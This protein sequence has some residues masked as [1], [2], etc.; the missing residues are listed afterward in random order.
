MLRS[1]SRAAPVI[2]RNALAEANAFFDYHLRE[3]ALLLR[4]QAYGFAR[5]PGCRQRVPGYDFVVQVW[6]LD[7]ERV[8]VSRR[9]VLLP[10]VAPLGFVD[11]RRRATAAGGSSASWRAI[12]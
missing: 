4:D 8:Y 3:T 7:G 9:N 2:Y 5:R 1:G 10:R 11:R 12:T 6:T